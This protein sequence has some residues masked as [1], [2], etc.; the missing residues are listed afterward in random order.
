MRWLRAHAEEY[1]LD[2]DRF[3]AW[4]GSAGGH[5]AALLGTAGDVEAWDVGDH[6]GQPSR[7]QAVADRYGPTDSSA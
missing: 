3:G 1:N 6:L 2:P 7:V 5:L 4:G